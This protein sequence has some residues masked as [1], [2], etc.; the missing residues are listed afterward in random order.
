VHNNPLLIFAMRLSE[1][2]PPGR[3]L[4]QGG[5]A[6]SLDFNFDPGSTSIALLNIFDIVSI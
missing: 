4:A 2:P 5:Q 6:D 3:S 1:C